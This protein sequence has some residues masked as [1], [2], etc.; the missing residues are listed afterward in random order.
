MRVEL[1]KMPANAGVLMLIVNPTR[2]R[3]ESMSG[4]DADRCLYGFPHIVESQQF[5]RQW[6]E[7][8]LF[9]M[10]DQEG[11]KFLVEEVNNDLAG[12]EMFSMFDGESLRT[13]ARFE[14]AMRRAGGRVV[15]VSEAIG[16]FSSL[17]KGESYEDMI[18]VINEFVSRPE[19]TVIVLRSK[20]EGMV[21]RSSMVSDIPVINAG[22]GPGQHPTQALLDLYAIQKHLGKIDGISVAMI[23]DLVGS[24]TIHSLAYLLGKYT[25][26]TIYFVSPEHLRIRADISEYLERH[27]VRFEELTDVRDIADKPDVFYQTRTQ[28][29][30]GTK[31]WDRRDQKQGYT[32]IDA[33]VLKKMKTDAIILHPLPCVDEIVRAEVDQDRRAVYI[34][35]KG[36]RMSQVRG[37]LHITSA[38]LKFILLKKY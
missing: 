6:I 24:R 5:S 2:D 21:A 22:D 23:G 17:A 26:I 4:L 33:S 34:K 13:R 11:Q 12:T 32:V 20:E 35:T 10:A 31:S 36:G 19:R 9:P 15:L 25:G 27:C 29:N 18:T 8:V 28:T 14:I 16:Q 3:R 1:E 7:Q 38:L 37:G 30:L